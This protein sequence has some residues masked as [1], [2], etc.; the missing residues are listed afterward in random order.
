[1][2][3]MAKKTHHAVLAVAAAAAVAAS[4]VIEC[5]WGRILCDHTICVPNYNE[6][7]TFI[8]SRAEETIPPE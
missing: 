8:P 6:E 7:A 4:N 5:S 3:L 1:M 2:A